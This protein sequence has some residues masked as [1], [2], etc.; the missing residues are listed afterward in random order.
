MSINPLVGIVNSGQKSRAE[1]P[2]MP[3]KG[4]PRTCS[5]LIM[6]ESYTFLFAPSFCVYR[7]HENGQILSE[8]VIVYIIEVQKL[9][10][11]QSRVNPY[12]QDGQQVVH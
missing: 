5:V 1:H 10:K 12:S 2:A 8:R 7:K 11:S 4:R 9:V 6:S 3:V